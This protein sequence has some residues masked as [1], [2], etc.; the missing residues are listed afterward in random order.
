MLINRLININSNCSN[1]NMMLFISLYTL[2]VG[3]TVLGICT[4]A[5]NKDFINFGPAIFR[6]C[7]GQ[8]EAMGHRIATNMKTD[9]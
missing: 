9:R 2:V 7:Q 6:K 8:I 4:F 3:R 1:S 5:K